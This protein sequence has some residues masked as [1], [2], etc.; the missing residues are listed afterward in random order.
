MNARERLER[1]ERELTA[2]RDVLRKSR[3]ERVRLAWFD[4]D[5]IADSITE[6]LADH[7]TELEKVEVPDE[8]SK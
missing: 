8:R 2:V 1:I 4:V 6:A 7:G 5:D 3:K